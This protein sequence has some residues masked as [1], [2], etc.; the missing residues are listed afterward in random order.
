MEYIKLGKTDLNI[1]KIIFGTWA[2]G[3]TDWGV[4]DEK[5]A[6]SAIDA[7]L[8]A[9]IT[10]IDTA[11][12]YGNGKAE[13]IMGS[14][15]KGKR[16]K[17]II[18]TKCGLDMSQKAKK[19]LSPKFIEID[20]N[21]SLRRLQTDYIDLYQ[22]HW[23]DPNTP[24]D[25]TMAFLLKMQQAGKIKHIGVCNF[26]ATQINAAQAI[27][28]LASLQPNYSLLERKIEQNE[29]PLCIDNEIAIIT[30]GSLGA[31][32][33]SGKYTEPPTFPKYDAR[34]FFYKYFK[35]QYWPNVNA[36][37]EELRK[38]A[39]TKNTKP[40]HVAISWILTKKGITAAIL[41]MRNPQQVA[42]NIGAEAV[43][44]SQEEINVLDV[45]S[46]KVYE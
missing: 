24:I 10:T 26:N 7:A 9:G 3:G 13:E 40:G 22:C 1:S 30:Y 36:V 39:A 45:V 46:S 4:S 25:E 31:G 5:D 27:A 43:D 16:E 20:L 23:P 44:L 42:D 18:A 37:I 38:I 12:A 28:P 33:L 34:S 6:A 29:L 17:V 8:D 14:V 32:L 41:G 11:P 21:N 15:L 2:I 19:D 35:A